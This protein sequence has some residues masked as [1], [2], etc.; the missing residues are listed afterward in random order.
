MKTK[1]TKQTGGEKMEKKPKIGIGSTGLSMLVLEFSA[2]L[3]FLLYFKVNWTIELIIK[4][5]FI[6]YNLI[7]V[8][9]ITI[10]LIRYFSNN[11]N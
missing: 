4:G 11:E 8:I 9:F 1:L 3:V 7:A 2:I 6:L 5:G 10:G